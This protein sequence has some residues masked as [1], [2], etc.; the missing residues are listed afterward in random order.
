M[1][2]GTSGS[3]W[4]PSTAPNDV[5]EELDISS[6]VGPT[7]GEYTGHT[8]VVASEYSGESPY[9]G[10]FFPPT[11]GFSITQPTST[12]TPTYFPQGIQYSY[13]NSD[14]LGTITSPNYQDQS[15]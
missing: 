6:D 5:E 2:F 9:P 1:S 7:Y 13:G 8:D 11:S 12:V 15:P 10:N 4:P 14:S 3:G